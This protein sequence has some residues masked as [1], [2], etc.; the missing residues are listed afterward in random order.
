MPIS[1]IIF[2]CHGDRDTN[3]DLDRDTNTVRGKER[4]TDRDRKTDID[5]DKDK[6]P[7]IRSR[8]AITLMIHQGICNFRACVFTS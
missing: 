8:K 2:I 5:R 1:G 4:D 6:G 7:F 3:R